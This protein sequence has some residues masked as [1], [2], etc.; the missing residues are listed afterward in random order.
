MRAVRKDYRGT[1]PPPEELAPAFT[2]TVEADRTPA[3]LEYRWATRSGVTSEPGW[4][5]VT[6]EESG[7]RSRQLDHTELTYYPDTTFADAV[8]LE[9]RGAEP[10]ASEW[11]DFSV[12]CEDGG[13]EGESPSAGASPS[14]GTSATRAPVTAG[15]VSAG[16]GSPQAPSP[17]APAPDPDPAPEAGA[18]G[19]E[20]AAS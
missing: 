13:G 2:A 20:T 12:T 6:Y 15:P 1:C 16:S 18:A 3:E 19:P 14:P 7:S 4:Q 9:L 10:A 11:V 5:S 17:E 8:R